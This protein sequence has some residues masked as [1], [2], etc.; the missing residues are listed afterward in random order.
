M[1]LLLSIFALGCTAQA[2][3]DAGP[4]LDVGGAFRINAFYKTWEGEEANRA[5]GGDL[6]FDTFRLNVDGGWKDLTLSAEYRMY[7]GYHMLH[8]GWV[9]LAPSDKVELRLGVHQVPF[10]LLPYASHNWF[11]DISYYVGLEDDYDLGLVGL[12][13]GE[14]LQ[15]QV[16]FFKNDEGSFTGASADSARYSYDLVY[17]T[18][19][20][21]GYAGLEEDHT[22]VETNQGNLRVVGTFDDLEVGLSGRLGMLYDVA[23]GDFG[24]HWAAAAHLRYS[25]GPLDLQLEGIAYSYAPATPQGRDFVVMGA[26]DYPYMVASD[27][28]LALA[29]LA[30]TIPTKLD[31]LD[32]IT[33]YEDY[34]VLVKTGTDWPATHQSVTGALL[35]AGPIYTYVDLAVGKNHPWLGGGYGNALA[36]AEADTGWQARFNVNVGYYF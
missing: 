23:S 7:V 26:Y 19:D 29:N 9:G 12:Y 3:E 13:T 20:E 18:P 30:W 15:V 33:L 11:F 27:G 6:A 34:S 32:S 31:N 1:T 2:Q 28:A 10:G 17:T 35:A 24:S 22:D 36:R 5:R 4:H 25:P 21:L 16:A 14:K 8:H